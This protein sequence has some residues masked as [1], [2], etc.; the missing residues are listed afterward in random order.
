MFGK[1]MKM[2]V[3]YCKYRSSGTLYMCVASKLD[4]WPDSYSFGYFSSMSC[5]YLPSHT[6]LFI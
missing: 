4:V 3:V 1:Q 6:L 2:A 5:F